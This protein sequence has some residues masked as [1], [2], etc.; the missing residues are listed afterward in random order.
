MA[1]LS[2][3]ASLA[4]TDLTVSPAGPYRAVKQI[5]LVLLCGAWVLLG[6]VGHDPWKTEDATSFGIVFEMLEGS[7]FITPNLAGEPFVDRPPLVYALAAV[8]G[9]LAA[10]ILSAHDAARLAAGLLLGVT[11][12]CLAIT[13]RELFG[14]DFRWMPVLIF[15]G[16][17]GLWDRA[18]Q[19]AEL[20]ARRSRRGTVDLRTCVATA[21][22]EASSLA[23]AR[24]SRS[25]P[26]LPRAVVAS[27][28]P[29]GAA[30]AFT[31]RGARRLCVDGR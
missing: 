31:P 28:H 1:R 11:L 20:G 15:I 9:R 30:A 4:G 10:G 2:Q 13:G 25:F 27:S 24:E 22:R 6:L 12:Y 5:G 29:G 3:K 7:D 21:V 17:V 16:C 26:Q 18:H 23:L 8:T 19:L 14:K